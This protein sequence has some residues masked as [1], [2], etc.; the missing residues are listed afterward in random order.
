MKRRIFTLITFFLLLTIAATLAPA[1]HA[2]LA[3]DATP[4]PAAT[5]IPDKYRWDL[6]AIYPSAEAWEKDFKTVQDKYLPQYKN[7]EGKLG[8][9][10]KLDELFKMDEEACRMMDKLYVYAAMKRDGDQA[11]SSYSEMSLRAAS[12]YSD[13]SSAS[14]YMRPELIALPEATLKDYLKDQRFSKYAH[15][16]DSLLKQKAHTLS[17]EEEKLLAMAGELSSAPENIA[18]KIRGADLQFPTIKDKEGKEIELSEDQY[19]LLLTNKDRDLRKMAYEGTLGAYNNSRNALATALD[20]QMRK[21][22]FFARARKYDSALEASVAGND[23]PVAVYEN[24]IKA[25]NKNLPALQKYITLRKKVLGVDKVHAYDLIVSLVDSYEK[26]VPYED[27]PK[28]LNESLAPLGKQYLADMNTGFDGR[29]IDVYPADHKRSGA[30]AWGSYDTHPYVLS[31]YTGSVDSLLE[32]AHEMGHAMNSYYSKSQAYTY[33][34]TPIFTAEVAS[35]TNEMLTLRYLLAN[36]KDDN[37]KL[38]YLDKMAESVRGTFFTQVM[39]AE[40]E[41]AIHERVEKGEA[42]SADSL[43]KLW[44]EQLVKFYGPDFELDELA[45]VG[46][47]RVPH[48]YYNFYVYQYATGLA[49][50]NQFVAN[51]DAKKPG[52]VDSYLAFLGAGSSDYPVNMLKTAGVDMNSSEPVD[53]LLKD[54]SSILDQMEQILIKQGKI[55]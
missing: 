47:S 38:Y 52:A 31:N 39:Y 16:F 15:L 51:I 34:N 11:D 46:W 5:Q 2:V 13:L 1:P 43:N 33:S 25:A 6:E 41:K 9:A 8:D 20:A 23:I 24:L 53:N 4:T 21:D 30:Y 22:I 32:I 54:F 42:L 7:Y 19:Y 3:A 18:T 26:T 27:A 29:W 10:A 36:A 12:L 55:K 28:I 40:F 50:S 14:A 45:K 49:A 44:G 17:K 37:E 35:T 48:L